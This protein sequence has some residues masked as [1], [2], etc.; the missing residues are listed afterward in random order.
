MAAK[1]IEKFQFDSERARAAQRIGAR[2]RSEN[3]EKRDML[4]RLFQKRL[5]SSK[6]V[7]ENDLLELGDD[8]DGYAAG[9]RA[10]RALLDLDILR[11]KA[12]KTGNVRGYI[13]LLK[14]A[15]VH[16]DQGDEA[17][18]SK[19]NPVNVAQATTIT[20]SRVKEISDALEEEC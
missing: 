12:K 19:D 14:F 5:F 7:S 3:C 16:F 10:V 1:D 2:R 9:K 13:E 20:A 11:E 15:G 8:T 4:Y 18:G 17:I 6:R